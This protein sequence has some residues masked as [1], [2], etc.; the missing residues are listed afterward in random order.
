MLTDMALIIYFPASRLSHCDE[1]ERMS[2]VIVLSRTWIAASRS[3]HLPLPYHHSSSVP[4]R[5]PISPSL[6]SGPSARRLLRVARIS[7]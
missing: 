6:L 3:E 2:I 5:P 4:I 7:S 1:S